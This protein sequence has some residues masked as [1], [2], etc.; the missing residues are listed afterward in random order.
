VL[1]TPPDQPSVALDPASP[2]PNENVTARIL[3]GSFDPDGDT[4]SYEYEWF[5]NGTSSGI[6]TNVLPAGTVSNGDTIEVV[7][8]PWDGEDYGPSISVSSTMIDVTAPDEPVINTPERY[9]NQDEWTLTGTCEPYATLDFSCADSVTSWSFSVT[10]EP[11]GSFEYTDSGLSRGETV[12]CSAVATDS[13]GNSSGVSNVVTTEVCDP[14]D[15][16]EDAF[17][18]GD[19]GADAIDR[20]TA[21][22]DDARSTISIEG[23]ILGT[24]DSED[25]YIISTTDD[26]A[27]DRLAG[28]DYYN[29]EVLLVDGASDY[30]FYVYKGTY[31]AVDLECSGAGGYTEYSDFVEDQGD[32][33]HTI[34]SET[35]ACSSGSDTYNDCEDRSTDYYIQVIRTTSSTSS[36][37]HYELEITNG[38][39]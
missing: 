15:V 16:Y 32:G 25:W 27:S 26:I 21:L 10:C 17:G 11:D 31:D 12:D 6:T 13:A 18:T 23:N 30:E 22:A 28:I 19:A 1:N 24:S 8:T 38:V 5:V 14:E 29:F 2:Q 39:W 33:S 4:V 20:W 34:P 35:R 9:R 3:T 7:V 37:Q 36:C